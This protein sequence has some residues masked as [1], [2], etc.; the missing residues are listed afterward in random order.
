MGWLADQALVRQFLF[1]L[2]S[3]IATMTTGAGKKMMLVVLYGLMTR[4]TAHRS[5]CRMCSGG[6]RRWHMLFIRS[7]NQGNGKI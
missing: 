7:K 6:K 5:C 3:A 1:F 2:F 4:Q